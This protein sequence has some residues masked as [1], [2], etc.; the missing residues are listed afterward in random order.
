M[1]EILHS[2]RKPV[3]NLIVGGDIPGQSVSFSKAQKAHAYDNQLAAPSS[4]KIEQLHSGRYDHGK[5][6]RTAKVEMTWFES[7]TPSEKAA[8]LRALR[9]LW[10]DHWKGKKIL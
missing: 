6:S 4:L 5:Q 2:F 10:S 7:S 3:N 8:C 1:N 9:R